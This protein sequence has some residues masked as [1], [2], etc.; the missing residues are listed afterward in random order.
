MSAFSED[1]FDPKAWVNAALKKLPEGL[2]ADVSADVCCFARLLHRLRF[3]PPLV[4]AAA[5]ISSIAVPPR[6]MRTAFCA[7]FGGPVLL[8]CESVVRSQP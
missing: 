5:F 1:A 8:N 3:S 6:D 7:V 4:S 2:T